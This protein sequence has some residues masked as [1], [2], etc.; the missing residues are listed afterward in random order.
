MM[1]G[2]VIPQNHRPSAVGSPASP[3]ALAMRDPLKPTRQELFDLGA[4]DHEFFVKYF[5]PNTARQDVPEFHHRIWDLAESSARLVNIQV[6]RGGAKTSLLRVYSAKRLAYG[7]ART[8]LF[9]GKS[10]DH[11]IKSVR[12]LKRQIEHNQ[13]F[14]KTFGLS[15][16]DKWQ[17][18]EMEIRI[19]S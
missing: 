18:V 12:W 19:R 8:I 7:I 16:G 15:K 2:G 6:F 4:V 10:Q 13:A 14:T 1:E 5:F 3:A 11:A 9:V 17:D